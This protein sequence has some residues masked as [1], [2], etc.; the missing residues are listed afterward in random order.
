MI[1][2]L[3]STCLALLFAMLGGCATIDFDSPKTETTAFKDTQDTDL[4]RALAGLAEAHPGQAGFYPIIDGVDALTIRL[5]MAGRTE[6]SIDAQY[7]LITGDIV[8]Y[9]FIGSLLEAADRGV[10]VRLLLD[11]IQTKGYDEGMAAL[12]SHP[13]FEVRIFNP[14][15]RR[16]ARFLDA[17][18]NFGRINR[19]MHNKSFTVDNQMTLVGG[20]N[21]GDEYFNA[22]QG[23][24]FGVNS[25]PFTSVCPECRARGIGR[26]ALLRSP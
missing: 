11:D 3:Q 7:Y 4:G 12:D 8:G 5:L 10:R 19:R 14:F 26:F 16:S 13:N 20:R 24:K 1:R 15:A 23:E 22:S 18:T 2:S 6:R 17:I 9:L 25:Y 21:I